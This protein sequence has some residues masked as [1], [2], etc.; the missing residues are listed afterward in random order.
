MNR[1]Y[2]RFLVAFLPEDS[3]YFAQ[4]GVVGDRPGQLALALNDPKF[5]WNFLRALK[6]D[7]MELPLV[8]DHLQL[9]EANGY[10]RGAYDDA[11]DESLV[12]AGPQNTTMRNLLKALLICRDVTLENIANW[13][14]LP[15]EVV[16]IFDQLFFN[17]RDRLHE[18][19]YIAQILYPDGI[20]I[21]SNTENKESLLLR[22]GSRHGAREVIR[23]AGIQSEQG[24]QSND[25][26]LHDFEHETLLRAKTLVRHGRKEDMGS[27]VVASAKALVIAD[28]RMERDQPQPNSVARAFEEI[29]EYYPVLEAL[30][31]TTQPAVDRMIAISQQNAEK[32][33]GPSA[34]G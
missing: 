5:G 29:S 4:N 31:R 11:M 16:R 8:I 27:P 21:N 32:K 1:S 9:Q 7:G 12:L 6:Q 30:Q 2:I 15:L 34:P 13:M 28:K 19:G 14:E 22:A 17:V 20:R 10:L 3:R 18:R 25:E 26:L 23:L 24:G 33:P